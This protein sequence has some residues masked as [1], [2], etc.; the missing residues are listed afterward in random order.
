MPPW[1]P[2]AAG[3]L[4]LHQSHKHA[5]VSGGRPKDP[6]GVI[7]G[8]PDGRQVQASG[9]G[10]VSLKRTGAKQ[11]RDRDTW[12]GGGSNPWGPAWDFL[13]T[14]EGFP[15]VVPGSCEDLL[16]GGH[17]ADSAKGLGRWGLKQ[18]PLCH[19]SHGTRAFG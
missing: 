13:G 12:C 15:Q 4:S 19:R 14:R 1:V 11:H 17:R 2:T 9:E 6:R 3:L 8:Q 18:S 5:Q 7:R 10:D 16:G